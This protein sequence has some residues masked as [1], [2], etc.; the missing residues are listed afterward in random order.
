MTD[1]KDEKL[2]YNNKQF[3]RCLEINPLGKIPNS[4]NPQSM[5]IDLESNLLLSKNTYEKKNLYT[6]DKDEQ[7]K[8]KEYRNFSLKSNTKRVNLNHGD[9]IRNGNK[10]NGRGFGDHTIDS[11]L[12]YGKSTRNEKKTARSHDFLD[13]TFHPLFPNYNDESNVVLPFYRGGID[14]R[15]LDKYRKKN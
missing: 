6:L 11:E 3:N 5:N 15:N 14:T 12:R 8:D 7:N 1:N 13:N 4:T 10:T 9:Y 2:R